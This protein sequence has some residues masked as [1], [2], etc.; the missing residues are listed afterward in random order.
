MSDANSQLL[1]FVCP[2]CQKKLRAPSNLAGQKLACPK[3]SAPIRVPGVV[4]SSN[5]DDDWLTLNEPIKLQA[6]RTTEIR[7]KGGDAPRNKTGEKQK[8]TTPKSAE[9]SAVAAKPEASKN[10]PEELDEFVLAPLETADS[11]YQPETAIPVTPLKTPGKSVFDD[12]LPDLAPLEVL[13][14]DARNSLTQTA[15]TSLAKPAIALPD[16]PLPELESP[17]LIGPS[18]SLVDEEVRFSCKVCG[19]LLDSRLSRIGTSMSCPDCYSKLVVPGQK[20]KKKHVEVKMDEEAASVTFAPID[21]LSVRDPRGSTEKTKE[22]LDRAEQ[23]MEDEREEFLDGS[24]DTKRWM[25]LLFGFLRDPLVIAAGVGAGF[26]TGLWLFAIAAMGTWIRLEPAQVLIAR[27]ALLCVFCLPIAGFICMCGIAILTMSANRANRV[28]EWPFAKLSESLVEC[29]MVILSVL[30]ASIPGGMIG[31]IMSTQNA[32]PMVSLAFILIG[33][34]GLTPI[35]LLSMID[36][37]SIFEPYSKAVWLSIKIHAE[38]WGAMYMQT[39]MAIA[40]F[41]L[42]MLMTSFQRPV[43]DFFLGLM[44][45]FACFFMFSQYGVLAGRISQ[46][47]DMGFEGDFSDD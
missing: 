8:S 14:L 6:E 38:A 39:G 45:P 13:P 32:H 2:K 47:T 35:L 17:A 19:S 27:I 5:D 31:A 18:S 22:I 25:G 36:N 16:V 3:C 42:F 26:A 11:K 12:E 7:F 21:S 34:W 20:K 46:V 9:P 28:Q 44:F 15:S 24:F 41:F 1:N 43:G 4:E 40:M 10:P 37:S 29:G 33:I 23:T 30:V